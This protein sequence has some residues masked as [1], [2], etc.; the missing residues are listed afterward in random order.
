MY[1]TDIA[2]TER[3]SFNSVVLAKQKKINQDTHIST[4]TNV[5]VFGSELMLD[6]S[7]IRNPGFNNGDFTISLLNDITGKSEG[8]TITPKAV[9]SETFEI[10]TAQT[11]TLTLVFALVIPVAVLAV[12]TFVWIR[13]RHK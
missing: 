8:I 7:V 2:G 6:A 4:Y 9:A 1:Q 5:V 3:G 13:R 10:T 12:G 11:R